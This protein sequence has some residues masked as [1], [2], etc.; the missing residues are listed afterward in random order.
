MK[1][2][3]T[4][5]DFELLTLARCELL[6]RLE[7]CKE[8]GEILDR[9]TKAYIKLY[10]SQLEEIEKRIFQIMEESKNDAKRNI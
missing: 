7:K 5:T 6:G 2:L 3:E 10:M 9:R 4:I 8:K 1:E